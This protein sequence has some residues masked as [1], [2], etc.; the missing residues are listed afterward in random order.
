MKLSLLFLVLLSLI[1]F[2][3]YG[4]VEISQ[5]NNGLNNKLYPVNGT[6]NKSWSVSIYK[7][8]D[9]GQ[10]GSINKIAYQV[11]N[12]CNQN[13]QSIKI[14]MLNTSIDSFSSMSYAD[15]NTLGATQVYSGN[16][17]WN[18]VRYE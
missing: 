7:P 2:N 1:S 13:Q 18:G 16:V 17:Y 11:A 6:V 8:S 10:A 5:N 4:Q 3:T 9:I 12:A 15:Q 14:Y